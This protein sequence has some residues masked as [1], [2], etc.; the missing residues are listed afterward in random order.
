MITQYVRKRFSLVHLSH[1]LRINAGMSS[2]TLETAF[3]DLL[4]A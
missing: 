2:L 3:H 1:A 4:A